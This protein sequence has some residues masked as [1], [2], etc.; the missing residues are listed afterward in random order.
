MSGTGSDRKCQQLGLSGSV[1]HVATGLF[2]HGAYGVR[3]DDNVSL[4]NPA[5]K[6]KSD[7][8]YIQAGIE[9]KFFALGKTTLFGEYQHWN[10][11][12]TGATVGSAPSTGLAT[13]VTSSETT[14]WGLG[15]NQAIEAAAMDVFVNYQHYSIDKAVVAPNA[16]NGVVGGGFKDF[17]AVIVGGIVRF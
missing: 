12:T 2:V 5:L 15:V 3:W 1:M 6:D 14:M 10:I 7:R 9:Q 4:V 13:G 16:T 8:Y 17:Q 11:G